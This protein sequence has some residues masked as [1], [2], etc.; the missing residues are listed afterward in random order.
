MERKESGAVGGI[1]YTVYRSNRKTC[2]VRVT[3]EGRVEV[4]APLRMSRQAIQAFVD[5]KIAWIERHLVE[6]DA[7]NRQCERIGWEE[8][9]VLPLL[10][11]NRVVHTAAVGNPIVTDTEVLLPSSHAGSR[12]ALLERLYRQ[13][14]REYLTLRTTEK[15]KEE[16]FVYR[17]VKINGAHG[18]WGSCSAGGNLNFSWLLI[19][20]APDLIDYVILHELCHTIHMNHSQSFWRE[21]GRRMPDY[22]LRREQL[23]QEQIKTMYLYKLVQND[24]G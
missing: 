15:A 24:K 22:G 14:A 13:E 1:L 5:S 4:K 3:A 10:G 2:V 23:R 8:G 20:V 9:Q 16:G 17:Q 18:R 21:V 19:L 7:K 11:R 6:I 12:G